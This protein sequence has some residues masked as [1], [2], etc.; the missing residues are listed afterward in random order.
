M[1]G[2]GDIYKITAQENVDTTKGLGSKFS[3][4]EKQKIE[5]GV[6]QWLMEWETILNQDT[7]LWEQREHNL[8]TSDKNDSD[9]KTIDHDR[10]RW[11]ALKQ[12][13]EDEDGHLEMHE[14]NKHKD[15]LSKAFLEGEKE[16]KNPIIQ[17]F[18]ESKKN[19]YADIEAVW[20]PEKEKQLL[21][22]DVADQLADT[23]NSIVSWNA[24]K[25]IIAGNARNEV[26]AGNAVDVISTNGLSAEE[27]A[28]SDPFAYA[29]AYQEQWNRQYTMA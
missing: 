28:T 4:D 19:Y 9:D 7:K 23:K 11:L 8:F 10:K 2:R 16:R 13:D 21:F 15:T 5:H 12:A 24:N 17:Q 20:S 14:Y 22:N 27:Y 3:S 6:D 25:D 26:V 18:E 29:Q 1:S